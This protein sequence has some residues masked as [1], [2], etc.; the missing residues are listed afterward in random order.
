MNVATIWGQEIDFIS[1]YSTMAPRK[2]T[3][4]SAAT[5]DAAI[6]ASKASPSATRKP[7]RAS[8]KA[9]VTAA[10]LATLQ[11]T[12]NVQVKELTS[13]KNTSNAY[14]GHLDRGVRFLAS[15]VEE[16][17]T[18]GEDICSEGIPTNELEKAFDKPPNRFSAMAVEMFLV[19]KCFVQGLGKDTADGIHGAFA[20]YWDTM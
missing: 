4:A 16:R 8:K 19:Q 3:K 15:M 9:R 1:S 12:R 18:R 14:G 6:A 17:R 2:N 20:R 10:P 5:A 7:Q 13:V 11:K